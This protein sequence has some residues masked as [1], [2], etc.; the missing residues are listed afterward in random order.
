VCVCV[1]VCVT[2]CPVCRYVQTPVPTGD[3]KCFECSTQLVRKSAHAGGYLCIAGLHL[4]VRK[5]TNYYFIVYCYCF[6]YVFLILSASIN[7]VKNTYLIDWCV[8]I[9]VCWFTELEIWH[10]S[11]CYGCVEILK[12]LIKII[13]ALDSTDTEGLKL[14]RLAREP[15]NW[16]DTILLS[17]KLQL[18]LCCKGTVTT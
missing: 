16:A 10:K 4:Y 15:E 18:I 14:T 13:I 7:V 6:L 17:K 12:M 3:N 1:C 5:L 9:S 11:Y 2:S 8:V